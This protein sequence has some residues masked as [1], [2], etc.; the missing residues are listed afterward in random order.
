MAATPTT[1]HENSHVDPLGARAPNSLQPR[2]TE[3]RALAHG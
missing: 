3:H 1:P 2:T